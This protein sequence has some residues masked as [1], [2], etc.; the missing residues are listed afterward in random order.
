[1][2][3]HE[4]E[5]LEAPQTPSHGPLLV[6]QDLASETTSDSQ[7]ALTLR[8]RTPGARAEGRS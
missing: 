3:E 5:G 8:T 2:G 4:E 6:K 7:V 1:M